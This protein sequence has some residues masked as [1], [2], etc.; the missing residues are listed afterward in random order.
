MPASECE[1]VISV[2]NRTYEAPSLKTARAAQ[3]S[4]VR[5]PSRRKGSRSPTSG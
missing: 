5:S 3:H 4:R 1:V 2:H